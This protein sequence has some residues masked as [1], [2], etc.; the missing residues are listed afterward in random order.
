MYRYNISDEQHRKWLLD[1]TSIKCEIYHHV[2]IY[3][4]NVLRI[5]DNPQI[6]YLVLVTYIGMG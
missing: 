3:I 2:S 6:K 4:C 1:E 5:R